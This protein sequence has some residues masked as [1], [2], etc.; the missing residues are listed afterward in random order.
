MKWFSPYYFFL[1]VCICPSTWLAAQETLP[2]FKVKD[3]GKQGVQVA[4]LNPFK[5]CEQLSVQR[6][7]DSIQFKTILHAQT[8]NM[9]DN[10]FVDKAPKER[11]LFYRIYY[12]LD[13][14]K[15]YFSSIQ[16][17]QPNQVANS[18]NASTW[19]P[20]TY[21]FCNGKGTPTIL[22][23]AVRKHLYRLVFKEETGVTIFEINAIK[24]VETY[25][26]KANFVHTGW[27]L[28]D[29]YEDGQLKEQGKIL[30]QKDA[31]SR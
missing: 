18:N 3:L 20:S 7:T 27:F 26:D 1:L 14:G 16:S 5:N 8:P 30:I 22:L 6:S 25:L 28:F 29:L 17:V 31:A 9:Y 24:D 21:V 2:H 12:V 15:F 19:K 13:G 4:W 10:G 23:P 11:P